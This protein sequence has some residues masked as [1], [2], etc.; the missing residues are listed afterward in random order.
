MYFSCVTP[1]THFYYEDLFIP[2]YQKLYHTMFNEITDTIE[3]LKQLQIRVEEE[4]LKSCEEE[5]AQEI[6]K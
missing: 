5:E 4:Y 1:V 6:M 2:N 3:N